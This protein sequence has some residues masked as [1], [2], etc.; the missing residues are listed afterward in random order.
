M[1]APHHFITIQAHPEFNGEIV[2]EILQSR[3]K[4]GTFSDRTYEDAMTRVGNEHHGL[5]VG[6]AFVNFLV[7]G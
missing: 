6:K 5:V 4:N 2:T 1:Y 3:H 7:E